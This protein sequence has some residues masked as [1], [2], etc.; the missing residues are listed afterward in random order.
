MEKPTDY[1]YWQL[2]DRLAVAGVRPELLLFSISYNKVTLSVLK[3]FSG[4]I[5]QQELNKIF[6][7]LLTISLYDLDEVENDYFS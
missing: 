1:G 3:F 4:G 2:L 5:V 6:N 7:K